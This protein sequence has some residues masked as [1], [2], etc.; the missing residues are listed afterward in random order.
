MF[1]FCPAVTH[2]W[3]GNDDGDTAAIDKERVK[4]HAAISNGYP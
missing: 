4:R 1:H 2:D 3:Y